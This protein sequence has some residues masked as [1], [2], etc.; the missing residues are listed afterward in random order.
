MNLFPW[1]KSISIPVHRHAGSQSLSPFQEEINNMFNGVFNIDF[2][3]LARMPATSQMASH[4]PATDIIDKGDKYEVVTELPGLDADDIDVSIENGCL[5]VKGERNEETSEEKEN[6]LLR[7]SWSGSF[8]RSVMLPD[9]VDNTQEFSADF[10]KGTL[11][12][13]LPK[14]A[15]QISD[16]KKIEVKTG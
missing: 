3:S 10:K 11:V 8:Y 15:N 7:E 14:L 9:N 4:A 1:N 12:V 5:T 6:Y 13:S 2:P 16:A